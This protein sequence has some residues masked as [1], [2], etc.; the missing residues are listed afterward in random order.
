MIDRF[1]DKYIDDRER[2]IYSRVT[3]IDIDMGTKLY[4][5][6]SVSLENPG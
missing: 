4:P 2:E 5:I 3:V 1:V 6:I